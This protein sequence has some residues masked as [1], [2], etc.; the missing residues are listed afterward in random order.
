MKVARIYETGG[1]EVLRYEDAP[2]PKPKANEVVL[3]VRAC[4]LN[5]LDLWVRGGLRGLK[6]DF[7]WVLGS[8]AAGEIVEVGGLCTRAKVGDK[9]VVAPGRTLSASYET[10]RGRDN[11]ASDYGLFGY[12]YPGLNAAYA[13]VPEANALPIPAG[14]SYEQAASAP[15]VFLTAWH[16]LVGIAGIK[17]LEDVLIIGGS[18]GVGIAAIQIAKLF[19]CRVIATAGGEAK[20]AKAEELGA[21]HVIDHYKQSIKDEVRRITERRGVDI[22]F[23]HVGAATFGHSTASL[24]HHG[25]LVT[26]GATTG[27]ETPL[28][29]GH[30]FAKHLSLN[31]SFMGTMGELYEVL[32]FFDRGLLRPVIDRSFPL[33]DLR[34]AHEYLEAGKQ[35]GKI[36]VVP[37]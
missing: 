1:P 31:G 12:R 23:E 34:G 15:L 4:S 29:L 36:T 7:P 30:L 26:C 24:A 5:H 3:R 28:N 16:M 8:D 19:H 25:R 33:S 27:F 37:E 32:R 17:M 35:F 21:D 6:L 13:A 14:L 18:S 11:W 10:A 22:V 20:L 9:V 2:E